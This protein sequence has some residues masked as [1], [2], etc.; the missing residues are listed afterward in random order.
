MIYRMTKSHKGISRDGNLVFCF[1]QNCK[2]QNTAKYALNRNIASKMIRGRCFT[3]LAR[4]IQNKITVKEISKKEIIIQKQH[5]YKVI[6]M[7]IA[8]DCHWFAKTKM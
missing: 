6:A 3:L 1:G 5:I 8:I 7:I 2:P 4:H